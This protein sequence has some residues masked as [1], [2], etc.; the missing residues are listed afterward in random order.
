MTAPHC[1]RTPA[2]PPICTARCVDCCHRGG[3]HLPALCL[4]L[5]LLHRPAMMMQVFFGRMPVNCICPNCRN[6]I[7][8]QVT[9]NPGSLTWL[10][11]ESA[12]AGRPSVT[13]GRATC[14]RACEPS[15]PP[16][17]ARPPPPRPLAGLGLC[18]VG[19]WPCC[20]L[21]FC[22][23]GESRTHP[24]APTHACAHDEYKHTSRGPAHVHVR[25]R[26]CGLLPALCRLP[27]HDSPGEEGGAPVVGRGELLRQHAHG[28]HTPQRPL[29]PTNHPFF[30]QCPTCNIVIRRRDALD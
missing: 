16:A 24:R 6:N 26:A 13:G 21:P 25:L 10:A 17:H 18:V 3:A 30:V 15:A 5:P 29:H 23:T 1:G 2:P 9:Y 8:T 19:A 7:T 20:L 22:I 27:G 4:A 12:V 14:V 11:C 28:W